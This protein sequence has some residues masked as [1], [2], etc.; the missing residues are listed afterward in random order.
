MSNVNILA[1]RTLDDDDLMTVVGGGGGND[2]QPRP[3]CHPQ[4]RCEPC[5]GGLDIDV[6]IFVSICGL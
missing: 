1:L 6:D 2:C 3:Q 4:P 5:G